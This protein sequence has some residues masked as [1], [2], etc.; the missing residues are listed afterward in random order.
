MSK[1]NANT[2]LGADFIIDFNSRD[3]AVTELVSLI[4]GLIVILKNVVTKTGLINNGSCID[5]VVT[6]YHPSKYSSS[7][8]NVEFSAHHAIYIVCLGVDL[9]SKVKIVA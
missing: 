9:T 1:L 8:I 7:V 4:E 5:N 3:I 6:N 2:V